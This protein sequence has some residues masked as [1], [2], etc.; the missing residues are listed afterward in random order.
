MA[1]QFH[2]KISDYIYLLFLYGGI[3]L[4]M[5]IA[6]C[7][8]DNVCKAIDYQ[9]DSDE[10]DHDLNWHHLAEQTKDTTDKGYNCEN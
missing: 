10:D 4:F 5:F 8:L 2:Q 9:D 1:Y 6:C 7:C 3:F